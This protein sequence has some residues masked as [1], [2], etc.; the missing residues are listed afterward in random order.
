MK[1]RKQR[2]MNAKRQVAWKGRRAQP[3]EPPRTKL[4]VNVPTLFAEAMQIEADRK[5]VTVSRFVAEALYDY[6]G[7]T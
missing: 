4:V 1:Q 7:F 6:F 5:G 2:R 3:Q